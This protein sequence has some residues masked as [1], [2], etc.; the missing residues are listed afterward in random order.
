MVSP[1]ECT[2]WD[3]DGESSDFPTRLS[4]FHREVLTDPENSLEALKVPLNLQ[5]E[6]G[7]RASATRGFLPIFP[8]MGPRRIDAPVHIVANGFAVLQNSLGYLEEEDISSSSALKRLYLGPAL[9]YSKPQ[10]VMVLE[11]QHLPLVAQTY[12]LIRASLAGV[13]IHVAKDVQAVDDLGSWV[14]D[15]LTHVSIAPLVI[16][17]RHLLQAAARYS[18]IDLGVSV[19]TLRAN[20]LCYTKE[21]AERLWRHAGVPVPKTL[22]AHLRRDLTEVVEEIQATFSE[23]DNLVASR[24]DGSGGYGIHLLSRSALNQSQLRDLY[25]DNKI[26]V[27]GH[28]DLRD[29]PCVLGLLGGDS[30]E[31]LLA[32][33]QRFSR[34]G[35]H[36]GNFWST[37]YESSLWSSKD[38]EQACFGAFNTLKEAGVR[39]HVNVDFL[40]LSESELQR[41]GHTE[42]CLVR[43][44][45]IRPA[46]S[47]ILLRLKEARIEGEAVSKVALS[48]N[49]R[50][51]MPTHEACEVI[52]SLNCS[53]GLRAVLVNAIPCEGRI[54]VACLGTSAVSDLELSEFEK[55]VSLALC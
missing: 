41:R 49:L 48:L 53:P 47:S 8:S 42:P 11:R 32:S 13:G 4:A 39:G 24:L 22:Y 51:Q 5:S 6:I 38:F 52:D 43:E 27:Q 12:P 40:L 7:F 26:Q 29:S 19:R 54:G 34:F 25:G 3:R 16:E 37:G 45:N 36:A 50:T 2:D 55:R 31:I 28:Y 15:N 14:D 17:P 46:G 30:V 9:L 1:I 18:G 44:A 20:L 10:D 23:F 21:G 33:S 35:A